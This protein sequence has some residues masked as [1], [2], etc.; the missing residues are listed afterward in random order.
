MYAEYCQF[1]ILKMRY[2]DI[3][4]EISFQNQFDDWLARILQYLL[5]KFLVMN[6]C[7]QK[8]KQFLPGFQV[9]LE[10]IIKMVF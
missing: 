10:G 7:G 5:G 6:I 9:I 1:L 8:I 4:L 3:C 2:V